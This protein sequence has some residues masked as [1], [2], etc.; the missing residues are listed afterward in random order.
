MTK[1]TILVV[2]DERIIALDI[3]QSLVNLGY[4]VPAIVFS[5]L[6]ALEK[7]I[8]CAPD[9][10]LMDIMLQGEMDGVTTAERI[11]RVYQIPVVYL[12]SHTDEITLQR[13]KET[14]PFGY[15]VK[16]FE[17][18]DLYTTVEI[19][20]ARGKAETE[21]RK[22]LAKERELNELKSRF[23][24][25]VSHEFRTPMATILFSAGLLESYG[26]EW[27]DNKKIK[28]LQRIQTAVQHMT[29]MLDYVLFLGQSEAGKLEFQP[30]AMNLEKF[31]SDL[32]EEMQL[33]AGEKH[34]VSFICQGDFSSTIMDERLLRHIFTNLLSNAIKYSPQGG[35]VQFKLTEKI[36]SF[37]RT[38]ES[39]PAK[40]AVFRI[41]DQGIGIPEKDI[42]HLFES[43]HRA[44]NVGTISGTGL[45]LAIV[46]K[47]VDLHQGTI[48]IET[49]LGVGTTFIVMLPTIPLKT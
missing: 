41:E 14:E 28:H 3:K 39:Q 21:M 5:G 25:M 12:T 35:K 1:G 15:I 33:L 18:K 4:S 11:R 45:G 23:V 9:L 6:Q 24:S 29:E 13:A 20:M 40:N 42:K 19:A 17:E 30:A 10:V 34:Q 49:K 43:F 32:S 37:T 27:P 36:A 31:C 16:P 38:G 8:Q 22:A 2:E 7:V 26:S 48:E 44:A 46:K 47:S